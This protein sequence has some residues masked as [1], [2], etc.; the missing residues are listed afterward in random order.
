MNTRQ[1]ACLVTSLSFAFVLLLVFGPTTARA[2][3][4]DSA[5][6]EVRDSGSSSGS[7]GHHGG[8]GHHDDDDDDDSILGSILGGI[9]EGIFSG[10]GGDHHHHPDEHEYYDES[11]YSVESDFA[12]P[13]RFASFPYADGGTGDLAARDRGPG[14]VRAGLWIEQPNS[15]RLCQRL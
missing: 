15:L 3:I 11:Y 6:S 12:P 14:S 4:F 9:L 13:A 2:G 8:G 1:A 10:G 7:G 5:R